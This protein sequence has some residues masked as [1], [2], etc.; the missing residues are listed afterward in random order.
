MGKLGPIAAVLFTLGVLGGFGYLLYW[1]GWGGPT[2]TPGF[3]IGDCVTTKVGGY[4]GMITDIRV[5]HTEVALYRI[6]LARPTL[7]TN[8]SLLGPDGPVKI[9]PFDFVT[10]AEWELNPRNP[11]A[12][13]K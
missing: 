12:G 8:T 2:A 5:H 11:G 6:R 3:G 13:G 10:M 4:E 1:V 7:R 9:A